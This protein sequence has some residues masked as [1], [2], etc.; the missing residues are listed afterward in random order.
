MSEPKSELTRGTPGRKPITDSRVLEVMRIM[1][2]GQWRTGVSHAELAE[3]YK[4]SPETVKHWSSQASQLIRL[5]MGDG[6]EVR[7][8]LAAMLESFAS[9]AMAREGVTMAGDTYPNPDVKAATGAVKTLA[10]L[11]GLM[12]QKH[13]HAVVVAQYEQLPRAGKAQWLREKAT[14]L[15]AEADRLE[16]ER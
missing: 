2:A 12:V 8:R 11:L 4:C 13:E 6:E 3:K 9:T 5:S 16:A 7:A 10:E 1:T 14:A 15:L